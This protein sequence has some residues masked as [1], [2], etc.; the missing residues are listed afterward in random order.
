[1]NLMLTKVQKWGNSLALRIP[2]AFAVEAQLE[3]GALVEISLVEG[4]IVIAP[5]SAST[6]T[7][8]DLLA[9]ITPE[10]L[11]TEVDSG[12]AVGNEA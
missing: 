11:H 3:N 1:M 7:L 12:R 4:K 6:W 2:Q 9:G 10:N 8:D 5:V